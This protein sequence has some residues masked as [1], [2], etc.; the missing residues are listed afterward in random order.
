MVLLLAGS[1]AAQQQLTLDWNAARRLAAANNPSVRAARASMEQAGYNYLAGLNAYLPQVGVSHS[2]SRSGG[3]NS[4]PSNRW[5][6]SISASEDLLN[7]KT[8]S[9]VKSSRISREK[10][11]ADYL[12]ASASARQALAG[13]FSDLLFAQKRVEVQRRILK[14]RDE[15]AGL[16]RLKYEGGRE[17]KGNALYT[18]A[19]AGNA[20]AAV[21]KTERQLAAA[22][23]TLLQSIGLEGAAYITAAGDISVPAFTLD[24][25]RIS[26]ALERSPRIVSARKSLEAA[27][28]RT[29][30]ARYYAYPTLKASQSYGWSGDR[31]F[32][33]EK[34]WSLGLSLSIPIFSGGPTYY[35][36]NLSAYKKALDAAGENFKA[37]RL[38]LSAALR[39]GYDDYL[40]AVETAQA[41][42][43]MLAANDERYREAQVRYLAGKVGFT[44]MANVEQNFVDSDLSQLDYARAAYSRKAALEQLLGVG[45]EE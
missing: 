26:L 13:A 7:L 28:E 36:N 40:S 8:V 15:N 32:P 21:K 12:A 4:S 17:S 11:E 20:A 27:K 38:S 33:R 24:E 44:D 43:S 45:V 41:G 14:I 3:D 5:S 6:A 34:S 25:A 29:S 39:S 35:F 18:E 23:R 22:R 37:E 1:A 42:A 2:F 16:I 10:A 19:L 30:S 31:E 9:S